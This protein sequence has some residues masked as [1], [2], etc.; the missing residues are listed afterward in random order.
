MGLL[1]AG[2]GGGVFA[3]E[4]E[5]GVLSAWNWVGSNRTDGS[6]AMDLRD[7]ARCGSGLGRAECE[8]V[9]CCFAEHVPNK[10]IWEWCHPP[11]LNYTVSAEVATGAIGQCWTRVGLDGAESAEIECADE[12]GNVR[13]ALDDAPVFLVPSN[14]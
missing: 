13:L 10:D 14:P 2:G 8:A 3:L 7:T 4:W 6:C 11:P 5:G 12:R 1:E 9:G